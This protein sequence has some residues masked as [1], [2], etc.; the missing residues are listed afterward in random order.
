[1]E[2]IATTVCV[3]YHDILKH[4]LPNSK[5]FRKWYIVTSPEDT[6]TAALIGNSG[7]TNMEIL[8]YPDFYKNASFNKG[9][10]IRFAQEYIEKMHNSCNLLLLDGDISLPDDF[11]S[12]LPPKLE[13]NILYGVDERVDYW[14][15]PDFENSKK[16]RVYRIGALVGFFQLYKQ[17]PKYLYD[18]SYNCSRCDIEFRDKFPYKIKLDV[19]VRHLG[20]S[21]ENWNGRSKK[22]PK[23]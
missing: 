18:K 7:L 8:L 21:N 1:M 23:Y 3:N 5:F 15:L 20:K 19:S 6:D 16:G 17:S 10:A 11:M 13:E 9:G 12:K 14:N 22:G 4:M 2:I